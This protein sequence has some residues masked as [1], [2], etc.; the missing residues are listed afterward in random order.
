MDYSGFY[1]IGRA[2][3]Q[4]ALLVGSEEVIEE[5]PFLFGEAEGSLSLRFTHAMGHRVYDLIETGWAKL[6]LFSERVTTALREHHVTGWTTYPAEVYDAKK[7]LIHHYSVFAVT[8]RSG[9][10]DFDKSKV[11][12]KDPPSPRGKPHQAQVGVFFDKPSWDGSD[13]F[14]PEGTLYIIATQ[15]VIDVFTDLQV[16]N[17]EWRLVAE[18]GAGRLPRRT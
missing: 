5:K 15:K 6:F 11:I 17:V 1:T 4:D 3:K 16:T 12:W 9:P 7:N 18:T 13:I 2:F 14:I 8:G 10:V